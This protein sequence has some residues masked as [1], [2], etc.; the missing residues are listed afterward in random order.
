MG[1]QRAQCINA[2]PGPE[3]LRDPT[4]E[5]ERHVHKHGEEDDEKP[6]LSSS[7]E[8]IDS[9]CGFTGNSVHYLLA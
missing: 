6:D 1:F 7:D 2:A 4:D 8:R 5:A 3:G 9:L